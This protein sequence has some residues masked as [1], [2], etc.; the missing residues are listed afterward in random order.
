[1][2]KYGIICIYDNGNETNDISYLIKL[3]NT[4]LDAEETLKQ[5]MEEQLQKNFGTE[6]AEIKGFCIINKEDNSILER[7]VILEFEN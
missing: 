5:E 3:E 1:M 4:L 2:K 6:Y 7:Y